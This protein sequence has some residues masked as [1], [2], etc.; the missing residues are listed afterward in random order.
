MT[1]IIYMENAAIKLAESD[2]CIAT[3]VLCRSSWW[4]KVSE[5]EEPIIVQIPVYDVT[6]E[7]W[8]RCK[9]AIRFTIKI[10]TTKVKSIFKIKEI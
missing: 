3:L 4:Q 1:G 10:K 9:G 5:Q 6:Q 2:E 7:I 8:E